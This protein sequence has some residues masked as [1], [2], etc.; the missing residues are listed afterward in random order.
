MCRSRGGQAS[1]FATRH[2]DKK[3]LPPVLRYLP[4]RL[5]ER[6]SLAVCWGWKGPWGSLA[7]VHESRPLPPETGRAPSR[8]LTKTIQTPQLER[9]ET[10]P[11]MALGARVHSS[12]ED[13][14][15]GVE[16]RWARWCSPT[17]DP[18]RVCT[19]K[20]HEGTT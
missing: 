8:D 12:L 17:L 20:F 19:L 2:G 6:Y 13:G 5:P 1:F 7:Q 14:S 3:T 9:D 4:R 16:S 10:A 11:E 18:A 15:G